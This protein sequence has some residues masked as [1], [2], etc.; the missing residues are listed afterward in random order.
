MSKKAAS[1]SAS[2]VLS[3]V[4]SACS[5]SCVGGFI[6]FLNKGKDKGTT[7]ANV[8]DKFM[9][10]LNELQVKKKGKST[11]FNITTAKLTDMTNLLWSG[12]KVSPKLVLTELYNKW[13]SDEKSLGA[14]SAAP[15]KDI[16][17]HL[18]FDGGA[19]ITATQRSLALMGEKYSKN[20]NDAPDPA[21]TIGT[22]E[23]IWCKFILNKKFH[24]GK[25][26]KCAE[27]WIC[28]GPIYVFEFIEKG[29]GKGKSKTTYVKCGEDEH[30]MPPGVGNLM[31]LLFPT[32]K[33]TIERIDSGYSREA[34]KASHAWC[35][36]YKSNY[37]FISVPKNSGE[38]YTENVRGVADFQA[39][40]TS[41]LNEGGGNYGIDYYFKTLNNKGKI[42]FINNTMKNLK[43]RIIFICNELNANKRLCHD[44]VFKAFQLRLCLFGYKMATT[45][46]AGGGKEEDNASLFVYAAMNGDC[47]DERA[48]TELIETQSL[49]ST[50]DLVIDNIQSKIINLDIDVINII[51]PD[52]HKVL[53]RYQ[54]SRL[55]HNQYDEMLHAYKEELKDEEEF[56]IRFEEFAKLE[57]EEFTKLDEDEATAAC[58]GLKSEGSWGCS[59]MGGS[60]GGGGRTPTPARADD[61]KG[62]QN[63]GR[64]KAGGTTRRRKS[65]VRKTRRKYKKNIV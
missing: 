25:K 57:K 28:K 14:A 36:H 50:K 58:S 45:P 12:T 60:G 5:A 32:L 31:G 15:H 8:V 42:A 55:D 6:G 53:T 54:H 59:I 48:I 1:A 40:I 27:C 35:N 9:A 34:L 46:F 13:S 16:R 18:S 23:L 19:L 61:K 47:L 29:K 30:V 44:E 62:H 37:L 43:E 2:S 17:D 33:E 63:K 41:I 20:Y 24:S 38:E 52:Y 49:D 7:I 56:A 10:H 3:L 26:K 22:E 64:K 65:R 4:P 39:A 51:M 11:G 21:L